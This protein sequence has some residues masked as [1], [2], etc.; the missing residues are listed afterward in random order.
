MNNLDNVIINIESIFSRKEL[1]KFIANLILDSRYEGTHVEEAWETVMPNPVDKNYYM[2]RA[3][4][5][6]MTKTNLINRNK[7]V[8]LK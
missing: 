8:D 6:R 5:S 4:Q 7:L 3:E 2:E 1:R